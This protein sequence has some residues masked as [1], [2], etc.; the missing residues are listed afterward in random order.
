MSNV[1]LEDQS[2]DW[3]MLPKNSHTEI[4]WSVKAMFRLQNLQRQ[5]N[6]PEFSRR[7]VLL[8]QEWSEN[9]LSG[10]SMY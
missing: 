8:G 2:E 10:H 1:C 6:M 4:K 9:P 3:G 7:H 5:W